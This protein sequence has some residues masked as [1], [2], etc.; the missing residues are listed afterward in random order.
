MSKKGNPYTIELQP[1]IPA[2]WLGRDELG[3]CRCDGLIDLQVVP[4]QKESTL[5]LFSDRVDYGKGGIRNGL[6]M[7]IH[8]AS[9]SELVLLYWRTFPKM[10]YIERI[11]NIDLPSGQFAFLWGPRKIG[12]ST[13]LK[14]RKGESP[15]RQ[16]L[17]L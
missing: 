1:L 6:Q 3:P 15:W 2:R 16:G 14:R 11:L 10:Q 9:Y 13:Y 8:L 4:G 17:A 5:G 12:K 7:K